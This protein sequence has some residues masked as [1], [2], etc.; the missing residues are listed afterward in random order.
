MVLNDQLKRLAEF[1]PV[2]YPVISLYLD[3]RPNQVGR[4]NF[5]AFVRKELKT[6]SATYREAADRQS[7]ERD[8]DRIAR[9]LETELQPS[10][11]GV[12]I[13]ACDAAGLF[14]TV[15]LDAPVGS[16]WLYIGDQPHLYPLARL[17]SQYPAYAAV[18]ADTHRT[19]ILVIAGGAVA[20]DRAITGVKTRATSQGGWSQA[21]YQRHIENYHLH[22]VKEVVDALDRIVTAERIDSIIISGDPVVMPIVREQLP[23]HLAE[24]VIDEISISSDVPEH[25]AAARTLEALRAAD[26]GTDR[27]KV[28]AAVGAFRAGGLGVVGPDAT[29]L[30]LTNGQVDELLITASLASLGPLRRTH[31]GEMAIANDAALVEPAVEETAAGE[32]ADVPMGTVR[33][34]DELIVKAQQTGARVSF[35]EDA[36]LLE[37]YGGV[38]AT[39]RYRV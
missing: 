4:D 10:A 2:P 18:L 20:S 36:S 29:L 37:P 27:E 6:R 3:T 39:L 12:A 5:D 15:Q 19:R 30:A 31:A 28:D 23:K 24:K 17:A 11:N 21:R 26:A 1:E 33:L 7:L 9:F 8:L 38:A 14:E 25:E 16:H 35:I 13:F 22:H 34:S 32:P